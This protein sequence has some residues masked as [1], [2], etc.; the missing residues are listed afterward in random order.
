MIAHIHGVV[1]YTFENVCIVESCGVGYEVY[2][3][4]RD[5]KSINRK[6][7]D[8]IT[9][10]TK[11]VHKEDNMELYGFL[12]RVDLSIFKM[13]IIVKGIGPKQAMKILSYSKGERIVKAIYNEDIDF[14]KEISGISKKKAEQIV[15]ELREKIKKKFSIERLVESEKST[16]K[17]IIE[18][19][20]AL[21]GLGFTKTEI[22]KALE[23]V[24]NIESLEVEKL[25]ES[26]LKNISNL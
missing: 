1:K 20:N 3:T 23:K 9:L 14:L 4:E 16:E 7:L 15:L 24:E 26:I 25:I 2:C 21:E 12:D 22:R 11:L 17:N 6:N 19:M 8:G 18:A 13:L 5:L 10:Y